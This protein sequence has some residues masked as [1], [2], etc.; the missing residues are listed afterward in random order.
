MLK[1]NFPIIF[2]TLIFAGCS[3]PNDRIYS[4]FESDLKDSIEAYNA[5]EFDY[6]DL[7]L[8]PQKSY[9]V[10]SKLKLLILQSSGEMCDSESCYIFD[11]KSD[12]ILL[13]ISRTECY[14]NP[15]RWKIETDTIYV[16]DYKTKTEKKYA[17]GVLVE[18]CKIKTSYDYSNEISFE[19]KTKTER[20]HNNR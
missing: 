9:F 17:N 13:L 3:N 14:Q 4:N 5:Q 7:V 8:H 15:D 16:I 11:T 10:N 12:S 6:T 1:R 20:K 18:K 19:I 2:L